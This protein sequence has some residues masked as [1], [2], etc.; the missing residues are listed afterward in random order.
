[1]MIYFQVIMKLIKKLN[2]DSHILVKIGIYM[3]HNW[4]MKAISKM[5]TECLLM[6]GID[7]MLFYQAN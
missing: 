3:L 7:Y 6:R 5:N 1:M 4:F 2:K